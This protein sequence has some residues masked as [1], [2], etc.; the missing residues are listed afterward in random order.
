MCARSG[1]WSYWLI[2][3]LFSWKV[4]H[5]GC[6]V[7]FSGQPV[8]SSQLQQL[9]SL[10]IFFFFPKHILTVATAVSIAK[11]L[12]TLT[13]RLWHDS[14]RYRFLQ[15][16]SPL[17][18]FHGVALWWCCPLKC[19]FE[20]ITNNKA[21]CARIGS[22]R[23]QLPLRHCRFCNEP[24]ALLRTRFGDVSSVNAHIHTSHFDLVKQNSVV[25][26]VLHCQSLLAIG[27]EI[28]AQPALWWPGDQYSFL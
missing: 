22:A 25:W 20:F 7:N 17:G 23:T 1:W 6:L 14:R 2:V 15:R 5:L 9:K 13:R 19:F 16:L 21:E 18:R 26:H 11:V 4:A 3:I 24:Q 12:L 27:V 8:V 28:N 10:C